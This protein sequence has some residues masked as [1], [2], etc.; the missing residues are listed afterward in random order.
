MPNRETGAPVTGV[1]LAGGE[2]SRFGA[3]KALVRL[4]GK[5]IVET[6]VTLFRDLFQDVLLIANDPAVF[7]NLDVRVLS[8]LIPGMG[9]LGG[10]FTGLFH[11]KFPEIFVAACDMPFLDRRLIRMLIEARFDVDVVVPK[12][13]RGLEPLHA[14]YGKRCLKPIYELVVSGTRQVFQFFPQVRVREIEEESLRVIAPD[15]RCLF[16]INTM[17]DFRVAEAMTEG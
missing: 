13:R 6:Q 14:V 17:D 3:N 12:S 1:I 9:P 5:G 2:S 8:D 16:N 7:E 4:N 10:I 11:A 15:L